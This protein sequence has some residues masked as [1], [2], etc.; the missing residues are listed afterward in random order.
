MVQSAAKT[1]DAYLE[2]LPEDRRAVVSAVRDVILANLPKGYDESVAYGMISYSIPLARYPK[3]YNKQPLS[4]VAL[5]AQK[6]HY[7]VY[8]MC[9]SASPKRTATLR[10]QFAK[11]GKKLDMGKACIRF[12]T[13]DDLPLDVIGETVASVTPDAYIAY[14]EKAR[15]EG[16]PCP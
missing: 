8:L 13:L 11:A 2:E 15:S 4:Y 7:A 1:V 3:T 10:E 12:K 16:L 6:N 9:M 14:Y 5:A